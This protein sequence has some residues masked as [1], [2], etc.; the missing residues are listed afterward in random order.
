MLWNYLLKSQSRSDNMFSLRTISALYYR[1][2][3]FLVHD[4]IQQMIRWLPTPTSRPFVSVRALTRGI[5][6]SNDTVQ[7][8]HKHTV[9]LWRE[10]EKG[11]TATDSLNDHSI[12]PEVKVMEMA[13]L[14]TQHKVQPQRCSFDLSESYFYSVYLNYKK[15]LRSY[16]LNGIWM[17]FPCSLHHFLSLLYKNTL[18]TNAVTTIT[19]AANEQ[20]NMCLILY[21]SVNTCQAYMTV[22]CEYSCVHPSICVCIC[23]SLSP[24]FVLCVIELRRL[25]A[26][27]INGVWLWF[28]LLTRWGRSTGIIYDTAPVAVD[29][30]PDSFLQ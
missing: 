23:G 27:V 22:F 26:R 1:K 28:G 21:W 7:W 24:T 29:P 16:R 8:Y 11:Q 30:C 14:T 13:T 12:L 5:H 3:V 2:H 6:Q 20:E 4:L 25:A 18:S 19:V 9:T 10:R 15:D 17:V